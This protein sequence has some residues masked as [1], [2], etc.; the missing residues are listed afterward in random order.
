MLIPDDLMNV[1]ALCSTED[2]RLSINAFYRGVLIN[3][4]A[5]MTADHRNGVRWLIFDNK[6][7][8]MTFNESALQIISM[9][10]FG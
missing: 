6:K 3:I 7:E 8:W 9:G 4:P 2:G 5:D 10:H 1:R